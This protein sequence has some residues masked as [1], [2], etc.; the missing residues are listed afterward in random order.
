MILIRPYNLILL[1]V[2]VA[3]LFGCGKDNFT[4]MRSGNTD[5]A[6]IDEPLNN[7]SK[8][9]AKAL[10]I[11]NQLVEK[12]RDGKYGDIYDSYLTEYARNAISSEQFAK[13]LQDMKKARGP[14]KEFKPSQWWFIAK[15]SRGRPVLI[16]NKLVMHESGMVMYQFVFFDNNKYE[17]IVG[18]NFK[19]SLDK[20]PITDGNL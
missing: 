18:L 6:Y 5:N 3:T 15:N 19:V 11:S 16:S 10:E 12:I 17:K 13:N 9:Y 8:H 1:A 2:T 20:K 14:Q 4:E 7:Q